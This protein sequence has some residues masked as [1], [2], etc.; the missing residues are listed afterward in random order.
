MALAFN[1]N[2][3][4]TKINELKLFPIK[5]NDHN[6]HLKKLTSFS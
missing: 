2:R 6:I 5:I 4:T 1:K 3:K